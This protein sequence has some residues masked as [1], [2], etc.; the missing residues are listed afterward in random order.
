MGN[1]IGNSTKRITRF[2]G[3]FNLESRVNKVLEQ[4]KPQPAPRHETTAKI[5]EQFAVD[6]PELFDEQKKKDSDL[7]ERL[8]QIRIDSTGSLPQ[9]KSRPLPERNRPSEPKI[10]GYRGFLD[11]QNV[12]EGR[13]SLKNIMKILTKVQETPVLDPN[14]V[15]NIA[16][17][18]KLD[19]LQVQQLLR[20][21]KALEMKFPDTLQKKHPTLAEDLSNVGHKGVDNWVSDIKANKEAGKDLVD[22]AKEKVSPKWKK[23]D[24]DKP[25]QFHSDEGDL[26]EHDWTEIKKQLNI[27]SSKEESRDKHMSNVKD[28]KEGEATSNND[29]QSSDISKEK[30]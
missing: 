27:K 23:P 13:L 29:T 19:V 2:A 1:V 18:Y 22:D 3:R 25:E 4:E 6:H 28:L 7:H 12:P 14:A 5:L 30:S 10:S 8:K 26:K 17:E 15:K 21:F 24:S 11:P 9:I 16:K 20:H